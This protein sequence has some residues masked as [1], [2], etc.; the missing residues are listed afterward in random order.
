MGGFLDLDQLN[1]DNQ[2]LNLSPAFRK[3]YD[4]P[5]LRPSRYSPFLT[6]RLAHPVG[7]FRS[8]KASET[9]HYDW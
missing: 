2:Y 7:E 8:V 9:D 5:K 4:P 1:T 6:I 3:Q